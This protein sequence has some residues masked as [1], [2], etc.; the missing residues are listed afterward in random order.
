MTDIRVPLTTPIAI[1]GKEA[2]ELVLRTPKFRDFVAMDSEAGQMGKVLAL[3]ASCAQVPKRDLLE[4]DA[5][6]VSAVQEALAPFLPSL[7]A[8]SPTE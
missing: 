8:S 2:E 3:I 1:L 5:R 7:P 6:D 4:M